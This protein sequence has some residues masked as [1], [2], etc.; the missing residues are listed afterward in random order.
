MKSS[1]VKRMASL[2]L[3]FSALAMFAVAS[4]GAAAQEFNERFDHWPIDLKIN[5]RI[6]IADE[7]AGPAAVKEALQRSERRT[8]SGDAGDAALLFD[9]AFADDRAA[10][11]AQLFPQGSNGTR[12]VIVAR[13]TAPFDRQI[14]ELLR[15]C[16]ILLWQSSQP[17]PEDPHN[18]LPAIR[19]ALQSHLAAGGT[20]IAIG[21]PAKLMS[22]CYLAGP[23]RHA[24]LAEGLNLMPDCVIETGYDGEGADRGRLLSALALRP[25]CVGIGIEK[26]AAVVLSGRRLS[27]AGQGKAAVL[28]MANERESLRVQTI[29]QPTSPRQSPEEYLIDLTQWRREAI[30]R[31]LEPFPSAEP[32]EPRVENGAL[33]I[34]GG[35]KMPAG[36][37]DRF[38]ELAGGPQL[39]RLIYIP[40]L[41]A[42]EPPENP[43]V[44]TQWKRMGVK[45][46]VQL[47]TK[48]RNKANRDEEFL[49]PLKSATG[50]WFGGGRQWNLADSY[51]GAEAHR[52]MK[53]VLKRGG[54]IGGSS[55]GASI[56]ARYLVR[57]APLGN[58][59]IMAPGYERGGLGFI[60][61]VAI[62]Q[63]FSQRRRHKDM[64]QLMN[65]YP[66]LLGIGLDEGTA[67]I[68]QNSVAEIVGTGNAHF[69]D[70][71]LPVFPDRPD[72][73]AL[74]AGA[75][76]DLARRAVLKEPRKP[77]PPDAQQGSDMDESAAADR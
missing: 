68:V 40:C 76:Y 4:G 63:H 5:G 70:R 15:S 46:A 39:A 35:G 30:D 18:A 64:T 69:Y 11:Y 50:I 12:R 44:L 61:G 9:E 14:C 22:A 32:A 20:I 10:E 52:L 8:P 54:V 6:V 56:Q 13:A 19:D 29:S 27:V 3:C 57:A 55:A 17:P 23:E 37:M 41:E 53:Q 73:I 71:N 2:L 28:L 25:R 74:P 33:V 1:P 43:L 62:D 42:E 34:V 36:L 67:I 31:T 49:T 51:Y 77:M 59:Q 38:I 26:E 75:A 60:S 47:H 66:Q 45:Q 16:N 58:L 72:Y 48:D 7:T 24:R 65:R 21:S